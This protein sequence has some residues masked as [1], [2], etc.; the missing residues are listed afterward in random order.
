MNTS[1]PEELEALK[2]RIVGLMDDVDDFILQ[3]LKVLNTKEEPKGDQPPPGS[4]VM[5]NGPTGTAYQRFY[6]TGLWVRAGNAD[7]YTWTQV[8]EM[9]GSS[10]PPILIYVPPEE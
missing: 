1:L 5:V 9:P 7:Q 10:Y 4:V 3:A 6:S 2:K 8:K